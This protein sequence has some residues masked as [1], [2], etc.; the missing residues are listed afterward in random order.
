MVLFLG[1]HLSIDDDIVFDI[2]AF[3]L[4]RYCI[5]S[6]FSP[7]GAVTENMNETSMHPCTFHSHGTIPARDHTM[8]VL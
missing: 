5:E 3:E 1:D 8:K 7:P 6:S 2:T 4:F